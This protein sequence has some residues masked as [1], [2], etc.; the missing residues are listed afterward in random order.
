[1]NNIFRQ[2]WQRLVDTAI[3]FSYLCPPGVNY[4]LPSLLHGMNLKISI[5]WGFAFATNTRELFLRSASR[6]RIIRVEEVVMTDWRAPVL[7]IRGTRTREVGASAPPIL[8]GKVSAV[9][10]RAGPACD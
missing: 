2:Q 8:A 1:M 4:S 10:P 9:A 6:S 7:E 5:L 3:D